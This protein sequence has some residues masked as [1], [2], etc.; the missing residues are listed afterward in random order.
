MMDPKSILAIWGVYEVIEAWTL[1]FVCR[2][3][4][5][6]WNT[7]PQRSTILERNWSELMPHYRANIMI[8][9]VVVSNS[10]RWQ[11]YVMLF[12]FIAREKEDFEYYE[13]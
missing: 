5:K 11:N 8:Y 12:N 3:M 10:K 13:R 6:I 9:I 4:R 2:Y 1:D 7:V